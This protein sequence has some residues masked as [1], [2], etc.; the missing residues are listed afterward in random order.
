MNICR[1]FYHFVLLLFLILAGCQAVKLP[2]LNL[3][4]SNKGLPVIVKKQY[5][6]VNIRPTP[7]TEN[8]A[9]TVLHGGDKLSLLS[10]QGDWLRVR[11][12]DTTGKEL[13][14]WIYKYLVEGYEKAISRESAAPSEAPPKVRVELKQ[15]KQQTTPSTDQELPESITISPL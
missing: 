1:L 3:N 12:F 6:K 2:E 15:P 14:G 11:F 10:E 8:A 9:L 13:E 7:G 4:F 5:P